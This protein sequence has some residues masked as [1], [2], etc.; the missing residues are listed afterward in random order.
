[1]LANLSRDVSE[2][3]RVSYLCLCRLFFVAKPF[4]QSARI[5]VALVLAVRINYYD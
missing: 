1:M 3:G 2:V 4:I 5:G